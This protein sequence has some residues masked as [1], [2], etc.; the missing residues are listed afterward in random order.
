MEDPELGEWKR[1]L[2]QVKPYRLQGGASSPT[3][4]EP[5]GLTG[6]HCRH[7]CRYCQVLGHFDKD[8]EMPHYLCTTEQKGR[9]VIGLTHK[10]CAHDLP[11]TCPYGGCTIKRSKYYLGPEEE[12]VVM[13]YVP[14]D[15]ENADD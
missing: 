1:E 3:G 4:A 14:T 9:C 11:R 13:D 6:H 10:H 15:G 8:C 2:D 5:A 7:T 12:Q